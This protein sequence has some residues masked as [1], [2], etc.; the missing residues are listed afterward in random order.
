MPL[1]FFYRFGARI[2]G[3][4]RLG[5]KVLNASKVGIRFLK[6]RHAACGVAVAGI[7][8]VTSVTAASA[9]ETR[10]ASERAAVNARLLQ[11]EMMVAALTCDLRP[12]Y[13]RAVRTFQKDLVR[14][15]KVL[16]KM[17]RR[18]HGASAQRRLDKY[19][20]QLANDASARSNKDRATYCRTA[21]ALFANVLAS[22][23]S[24]F[25]RLTQ[26]LIQ[27]AALPIQTR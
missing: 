21:T 22:G 23:P 9:F 18:D 25:D 4:V 7:V 20:T 12:Q 2:G 11:T 16:R 17:F 15:G 13:N 26:Q 10:N 24:G 1:R 8:S 5:V 6:L 3:N 19:I 14:H 27:E